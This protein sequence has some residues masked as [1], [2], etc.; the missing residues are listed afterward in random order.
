[1]GT[2]GFG[3]GVRVI[4][5]G[6]LGFLGTTG[7]SGDDSGSESVDI[8]STICFALAMK[9]G[10]GRQGAGAG[11]A[12][13]TAGSGVGVRDTRFTSS[14]VSGLGALVGSGTGSRDAGTD[15]VLVAQIA[16]GHGGT[17]RVGSFN[18]S[19]RKGTLFLDLCS[20]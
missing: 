7:G 12:S 3:D 20:L 11:G 6:N 16:E 2:A 13:G 1:M 19:S 18:T 4:R 17:M 9:A 14:G 10:V 8:S 5:L 15:L